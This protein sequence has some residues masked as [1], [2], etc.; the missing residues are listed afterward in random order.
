MMLLKATLN[1]FARSKRAV[2]NT[3][4][5]S[6]SIPLNNQLIKEYQKDDAEN[7]AKTSPPTDEHIDLRCIWGVE[8][9]TPS[10]FDS[11]VD[12]F[13]ELG[14]DKDDEDDGLFNS[15]NPVT[16]LYNQRRSQHGGSWLNLGILT[17]HPPDQ[18]S[19]GL[20]RYAPLPPGV[21][22]ASASIY[23]V[24]PSL[25][26]IVIH[27]QFER[28]S[29]TCFEQAL[30]KDRQTFGERRSKEAKSRGFR[31]K[32]PEVQKSEH[33]SRIRSEKSKQ[34][35]SWFGQNLPGLFSSGILQGNVPTCEFTTL[36]KAEPFPA[37]EQNQE[38]IPTYLRLLGL[39]QD[40]AAWES[41]DIPGLRFHTLRPS[42]D[43]FRYHSGFAVKEDALVSALAKDIPSEDELYQNYHLN[44][45]FSGQISIWAIQALLEGYT[46]HINKIRDS[47]IFKT[48][49]RKNTVK[50]LKELGRNISHSVDIAAVATELI[51]SAEQHRTLA[52]RV[53]DFKPC[54]V[55]IYGE[56]YPLSK[57]L[58][59]TI[60]RQSAW[61]KSTDQSLR[62]HLTQYG[63]LL[64][65]AEEVQLQRKVNC[66]TWILVGLTLL[67]AGLAVDAVVNQVLDK[68]LISVILE[69]LR[70]TWSIGS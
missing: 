2:S 51:A 40:L 50:V 16:W 37:R 59:D 29:S 13:C 48:G 1:G 26:C 49:V 57:F 9:Y 60:G 43:D 56:V 65:A 32:T 45:M 3:F 38:T 54:R 4:G 25:I 14:W 15:R 31:I 20:R 64:A 61:I 28:E 39:D 67:S 7:N 69:W 24:S 47:D 63:S 5:R 18:S 19:L 11:L 44:L 58:I 27:F 66:L 21:G 8:F 41:N 42:D 70:N 52:R 22:S 46:Y 34:V 10:C 35:S 12:A 23:S 6:A 17:R 36:R 53:K 30:K 68:S 62:D 55:D 33:I